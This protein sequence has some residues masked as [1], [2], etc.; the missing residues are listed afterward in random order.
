MRSSLPKVLHPLCGRPLIAWPIAAAREAGAGQGRRGRRPEAPARRPSSR[1]RRRRR[2]G[3]AARH[4][5]RGRRRRGEIGAR[6]PSWSYGRRPADRRPTTLAGLVEAHEDGRRRDDADRRA[7]GP[8]G[9]GR[10][11]RDAEGQV[12]RV[13]E[14]KAAGDASAAGARDP[15]GQHGHLRLRRRRAARG[16]RRAQV[17][18]RP[19]RALPARRAAAH[20]RR[21]AAQ[22]GAHVVADAT[23]TLG[24]NDRADLARVRAHRAAAHPRG[25]HARRRDDRRPGR[26][27][28]RRRRR[29][30]APTPW[31]SRRCILRGATTIGAGCHDRR[32]SPRSSTPR[33]ATAPR[34]CTP[35]STARAWTPSATV[36][37][38]AYLRPGRASCDEGAKAG[39]FV[40][41]KNSDHRRGRK[42]PHL[43]YIGDADIGEGTN[44]GAAR[45][46][47]TTT[48]Q[49][50]TAPRSATACARAWTRR[51]SPR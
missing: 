45:S 3:R 29:R 22:I 37:P 50:S 12:E 30:S 35:T 36:G 24:I 27:D 42:V 23:V 19:G 33:S 21:P 4:G 11:V 13:V 47:P 8:G 20:A 18:Q 49:T 48:G 2:P 34:S 46:P 1:G 39:T 16:A 17:R 5:R 40:E 10:V 9:Y 15:R 14:T 7:R 43:S 25:P 6:P 44:L 38:F 41:I 26:D 32:R 28:D 31:S 51:S